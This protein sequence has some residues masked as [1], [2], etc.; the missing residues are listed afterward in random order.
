MTMSESQSAPTVSEALQATNQHY[1][2]PAALFAQF[3]DKRL[4][5]SSGLYTRPGMSLDDAQTEKLHFIAR[6]IRAKSAECLLDI[7]CGWGS[8]TLFMAQEYGHQVTGVTPCSE[9]ATYIRETAEAMGISD[10]VAVV[11]GPFSEVPLERRFDAVTMVGSINHMPNQDEVMSKVYRHMREGAALYLSE[12]C[13]RSMA[14]H[15]EFAD[16]P[17]TRQVTES[18]FGFAEMHPLSTL[19]RVIESAGLSVTD[20]TDLTWHFKR[21]INDWVDC[22]VHNRERIEDIAAGMY[23]P[24]RT[25]LDTTNTAWGFTTKQYAVVA[26]RSRLG[27]EDL[28]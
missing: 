20:V 25:Y 2:L 5:Y 26:V 27:V 4:K 1:Q 8:L 16:R 7:G 10:R 22:A 19:V 24:L 28:W 17:A 14:K 13:F 18:I 3:L 6:Q 11:V 21:T 12:S 9:Q 15:K 23:E